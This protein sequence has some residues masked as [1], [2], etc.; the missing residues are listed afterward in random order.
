M[1]IVWRD[2][3]QKRIGEIRHRPGADPGLPVRGDIGNPKGAVG[4][5]QS[6]AATQ[7]QPVRLTGGSV[8]GG[9]AAGKKNSPA[10]LDIA[11]DEIWRWT[12]KGRTWRRQLPGCGACGDCDKRA[13]QKKPE[14]QPC[15]APWPVST[16]TFLRSDIG[17][18]RAP[19]SC[20]FSNR[21][22]WKMFRT[23]PFEKPQARQNANADRS[24]HHQEKCKPHKKPRRCCCLERLR[25]CAASRQ[26]LRLQ[27]LLRAV[28]A[29]AAKIAGCWNF[30]AFGRFGRPQ[31]RES[32]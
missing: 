2:A 11:W 30:F 16:A 31:P 4:R 19:S 10:T 9:A 8:A 12:L 18:S 24:D 26:P 25:I 29:P 23:D 17:H 3:R 6:E 32:A 22:R 14:P 28:S 7:A 27:R 21:R 5:G 1:G 20:C 15:Q 13:D